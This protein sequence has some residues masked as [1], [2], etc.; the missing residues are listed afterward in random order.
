MSFFCKRRSTQESVRQAGE[1]WTDRDNEDQ[2]CLSC[3]VGWCGD[4]E[5]AKQDMVSLSTTQFELY[6]WN[7]GG[8]RTIH[9]NYLDRDGIEQCMTKMGAH[10]WNTGVVRSVGAA[11][12]TVTKP[13]VTMGEAQCGMRV[14]TQ[15]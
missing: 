2:K 6:T 13:R 8:A 1:N 9:T 4:V 14:V 11:D 12:E 7:T 15:W 10:D 3:V 5:C